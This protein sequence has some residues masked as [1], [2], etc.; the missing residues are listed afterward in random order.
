MKLNKMQD[1][2][3]WFLR[4]IKILFTVPHKGV[5]YKTILSVA[6]HASPNAHQPSSN[7]PL[8]VFQAK[9]LLTLVLET[10]Q[11]PELTNCSAKAD[12]TDLNP[13]SKFLRI[14]KGTPTISLI[15]CQKKK[16]LNSNESRKLPLKNDLSTKSHR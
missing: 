6:S 16:S 2:H 11:L 14:L 15:E 10:L 9:S 12:H 1:F 7:K 3:H 5:P 13:S 8:L 4:S